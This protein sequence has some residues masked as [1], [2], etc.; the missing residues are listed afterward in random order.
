MMQA[1]HHP[2]C[3]RRG[4]VPA[5]ASTLWSTSATAITAALIV[6]RFFGVL[7]SRAS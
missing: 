6:I 7:M 3:E 1:L 5:A 4:A 2:I